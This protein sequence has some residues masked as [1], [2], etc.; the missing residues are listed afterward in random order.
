MKLKKPIKVQPPPRTQ[1][2]GTTKKYPEITIQELDV[3]FLDFCLHKYVTARILP[4]PKTLTLWEGIEY[5]RIG[6]WTQ[7]QAENRL[8]EIL[9][10]N[11]KKVLEGLFW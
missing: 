10:E 4:C 11:P 5:D 2:D 1:T 8:L 3:M 6:D 9:G 7:K